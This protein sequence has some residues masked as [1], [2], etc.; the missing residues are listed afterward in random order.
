M[1]GVN[2]DAHRSP[3]EK[4]RPILK[5]YVETI[6]RF[7]SPYYEPDWKKPLTQGTNVPARE[8]A[9]AFPDPATRLRPI[10]SACDLVAR[11]HFFAVLIV[12]TIVERW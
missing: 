10:R 1:C 4:M 6:S 9:P 2:A 7:T 8:I 5:R 3:G 11:M 12:D